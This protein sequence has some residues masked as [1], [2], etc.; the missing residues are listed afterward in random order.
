VLVQ[1]HADWSTL[2]GNAPLFENREEHFLLRCVVALIGKLL[3]KPG[4]PLRVTIGDRFA[5]FDSSDGV[6]QEC[7]P[8]YD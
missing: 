8:P 7:K 3:E 5:R 4:R 1:H 6:L 2:F